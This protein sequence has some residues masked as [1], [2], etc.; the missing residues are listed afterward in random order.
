MNVAILHN[1]HAFI[2]A[3]TRWLSTLIDARLK[4]HANS[5]HSTELLAQ[6][7]PP[8]MGSFHGP[9]VELIGNRQFSSRER[10][11]V[12]LAL[13]AEIAPHLLDP[14]RLVNSA[15][16]RRFT[17]FGGYLDA[18]SNQ[19]VPT[20]QTALF[21]MVGLDIDATLTAQRLFDRTAPLLRFEVLHPVEQ[22]GMNS[23]L[24]GL[25]RLTSECRNLLLTGRD[26]DP[27]MSAEFPAQKLTTNYDW[28]DLILTNDIKEDVE[29]ILSWIKNE[30]VL[31]NDWGLRQR[32]APG[33]R[34]LFCGPPGTGKTLTASLL[35]KSTGRPVYR[36]DI[37]KVVSKYI[38]ET[39]KN[40]ASLFDRA[41][42]RD[43]ILFFDEADSLFGKRGDGSTASDRAGNQNVSYLLQRIELFKGVILLASNLRS[44]IDEAFSRRFQSIVNF[45][46]PAYDERYLLWQDNFEQKPFSLAKNVDL[47]R[48]ARDYEVSG[49]EI[50]NVLRT[51]CL[52]AVNR[53]SSE[54]RLEDLIRAI[55]REQQ[56]RGKFF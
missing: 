10:L 31:M 28:D 21:L 5:S 4:N 7:P 38:G 42:N 24:S 54:I 14:F 8:D 16:G 6:L 32:I 51:A 29:E 11:I 53:D 48:I 13:A 56:K 30:E 25:L 3:E 36:V 34:S 49:G 17:E 40:M 18:H 46:M 44:N 12:A 35:G 37:S 41:E 52:V 26:Y 19:L 27:P 55:K 9:Y 1:N 20:I 50:I 15:I 22:P 47:A 39:E 2:E 33:F 43:W 23:L 45:K